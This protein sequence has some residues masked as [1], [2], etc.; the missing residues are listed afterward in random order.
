VR[1][2]SSDR[3]SSLDISRGT[4]EDPPDL[5]ISVRTASF[6][7]ETSNIFPVKIP[8]FLA[9]LD[10][11]EK[12][13]RGRA[14]LEGTEDF[15]LV[16][17]PYGRTGAIWASVSISHFRH[18]PKLAAGVSSDRLNCGFEVAG[19]NFGQLCIELRHVLC[20]DDRPDA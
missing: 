10:L 8:Q 19:E 4:F 5:D 7:G 20:G 13:R 1:I 17:Q 16:L 2:E 3:R 15:L 6:S 14:Q 9:D 11:L 18:T 12:S